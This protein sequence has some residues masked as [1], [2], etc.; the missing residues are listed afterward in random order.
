M[1]VLFSYSLYAND[2]A[3]VADFDSNPNRSWFYNLED[4]VFSSS[5]YVPNGYVSWTSWYIDGNYQTG[6]SGATSFPKCFALYGSPAGDCYQLSNGQTTV[7]IKVRVQ[8]NHGFWDDKTITYTIQQH[9]G[10]KYFVK[11]H[12]GNVRTT[13]NR[14]GNVLGHDDYYPFGLAMPNHS[15]NIANPND[16]YKFT[17][18]ELDDEAGLNIYHMNARGMDPVTGRF[19]QID[20]LANMFPGWSSYSYAFNNPIGYTD[21]TGM[22]PLSTHTDSLGNVLAVYNDGDLGVYQHDDAT[23]KEEVDK[24]REATGTTSGGGE[25][26]GRTAFWDEFAAH[27]NKTGNVIRNSDG[28]IKVLNNSRI[29]FGIQINTLVNSIYTVG[30]LSTNGVGLARLAYQS[31]PGQQLDIKRGPLNASDGYMLNGVYVTGRSAGNYLAGRNANFAGQSWNRTIKAAGLLHMV[32][33]GVNPL[34]GF[35]PPTYG[36]IPSAARWIQIGYK[37]QW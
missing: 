19:M 14:D 32:S 33:S 5:S 12:L 27:D 9:K 31:S 17:G 13:V 7:Q 3:P 4:V 10:R 2:L 29:H 21:P 1:S 36:E 18:H 28:S 6:G 24:K 16:N 22:A 15:N 35:F 30:N 11:D 8:S 20:P 23:T 34:S 25:N 37:T 26:M